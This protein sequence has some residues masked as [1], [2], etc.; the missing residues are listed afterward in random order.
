MVSWKLEKWHISYEQLAACHGSSHTTVTSVKGELMLS[1]TFHGHC[2][3]KVYRHTCRQNIHAH[4]FFSKYFNCMLIHAILQNTLWKL[5]G[6][7]LSTINYRDS[8][9]FKMTHRWQ[10]GNGILLYTELRL[11]LIHH[12]SKMFPFKGTLQMWAQ[13]SFCNQMSLLHKW[14]PKG[15]YAIEDNQ[16]PSSSW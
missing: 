12:Y 14:S 13:T 6:K 8:N 15:F 2:T 9:Q 16:W 11:S 10:S 7:L 3:H 5:H 4:T 1:S